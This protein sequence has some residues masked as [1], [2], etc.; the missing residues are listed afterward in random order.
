MH[1]GKSSSGEV[2]FGGVH[3]NSSYCGSRSYESSSVCNRPVS[4]IDFYPTLNELC[5]LKLRDDLNGLS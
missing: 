3:S 2:Y 5:G 4:L 1:I